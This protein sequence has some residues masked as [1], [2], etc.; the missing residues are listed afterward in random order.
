MKK[1]LDLLFHQTLEEIK[2][3][4]VGL[5]GPQL[6]RWPILPTELLRYEQTPVPRDAFDLRSH[7]TLGFQCH[8]LIRVEPMPVV[9][10]LEMSVETRPLESGVKFGEA[11]KDASEKFLERKRDRRPESIE[12]CRRV[13][14]G[15]VDANTND[16]VI[17]R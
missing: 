1:R 4:A 5:Q 14:V 16:G 17:L 13:S 7:P 2:A 8:N 11:C 10:L 9:H 3:V 6:P 15:S 12:R